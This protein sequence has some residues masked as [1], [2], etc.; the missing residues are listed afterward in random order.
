[1]VVADLSFI[2]LRTAAPV[3]VVQLAAPGADV[4]ALVKPQFEAGRRAVSA[5][6]G[7]IRDPSVWADV[8]TRVIGTLS[9]HG[10]AMMGVMT[11]PLTGA[12]GNVEFLGHFRTGG[13]GDAPAPQID[14]AVATAV[15]LVGMED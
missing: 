5:G 2:S 4:V 13:S 11:S 15:R 6:R 10:A 3:L 8:L 14:A 9:D 12:D 7:V 1:V